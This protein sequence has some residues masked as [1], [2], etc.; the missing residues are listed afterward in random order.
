MCTTRWASRIGSL[1][2][3][4][5]LAA[6][7]GGGSSGGAGGDAVV[8]PTQS[9]VIAYAGDYWQ[10]SNGSLWLFEGRDATANTTYR[11]PTSLGSPMTLDGGVDARQR[12]GEHDESGAGR[13]GLPPLRQLIA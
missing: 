13:A 8:P 5:V 7:G 12:V 2:V 6:C 11:N 9:P 1:F 10:A 3:F 4:L